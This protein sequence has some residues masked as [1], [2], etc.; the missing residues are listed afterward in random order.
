M[1]GM[2]LIFGLPVTDEGYTGNIVITEYETKFPYAV[3]IKTKSSTE[4]AEK[5]FEYVSLFGPPRNWV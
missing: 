3:P 4:I 1:C 5:L 2:D